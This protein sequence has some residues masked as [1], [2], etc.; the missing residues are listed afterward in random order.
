[1]GAHH[2]A[3]IFDGPD[4]DPKKDRTVID[5]GGIRTVLVGVPSVSVAAKTAVELVEEGA[6]FIELCGGFGPGGAALAL[7]SV[8]PAHSATPSTTKDNATMT[9]KL[10]RTNT[11]VM[12]VDHQQKLVAGSRIPDPET[13]ARNSVGLVKAAKILGLPIIATSNGKA[14]FGP[15]FPELVEALG[16]IEVIERSAIDTF[17]DARVT[18]AV[19]ATGR[20]HLIVAGVSLPVCAAI[21]ALSAAA[22]GLHTYV[23]IDASAALDE[24]ELQTTMHRLSQAGIVNATYGALICEILADNADPKAKEVYHNIRTQYGF[25]TIAA[26]SAP[27]T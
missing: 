20:T 19:Q 5:R 9:P 21:P 25:S 8:I 18:E 6:Q 26:V 27:A 16:D 3:F 2:W 22:R 7:A 23:A 10:T 17:D 13:L 15:F 14:L 11:A 1:M 24:L 4:L 12:L